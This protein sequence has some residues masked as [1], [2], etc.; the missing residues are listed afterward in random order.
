MS[1]TPLLLLDTHIWIWWIEQD[2]RLPD[3]IRRAI[4]GSVTSAPGAQGSRDTLQSYTRWSIVLI[5]KGVTSL[6]LQ[7]PSSADNASLNR[8]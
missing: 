2:R 1:E 4:E 6:A 8:L 3:S 5:L 7:G